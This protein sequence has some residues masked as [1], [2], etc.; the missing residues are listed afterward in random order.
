M[1]EGSIF[2]RRFFRTVHRSPPG[3]SRIPY[4]ALARADPGDD[5]ERQSQL[6]ERGVDFTL[7]MAERAARREEI[8]TAYLIR[9]WVK[10]TEYC[11]N[12]LKN[13]HGSPRQC[14]NVVAR[15]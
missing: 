13:K 10:M 11:N 2:Q 12:T 14:C 4:I 5:R 8:D 1:P 3:S 6:S 7:L 9:P 15:R